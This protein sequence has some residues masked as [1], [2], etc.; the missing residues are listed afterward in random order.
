MI[1]NHKFTTLVAKPITL[2]RRL[3]AFTSLFA[4]DNKDELEFNVVVIKNIPI[5]GIVI[6]DVS[7]TFFFSFN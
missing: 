6:N 2:I 3:A 4:P 1:D 7:N 5:K